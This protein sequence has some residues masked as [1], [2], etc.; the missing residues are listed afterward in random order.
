[1]A[2]VSRHL[3]IYDRYEIFTSIA[4]DLKSTMI[5]VP[6]GLEKINFY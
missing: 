1:M 3:S 6:H 4:D 5:S 2:A